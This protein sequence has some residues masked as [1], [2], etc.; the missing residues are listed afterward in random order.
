MSLP[1]FLALAESLELAKTNLPEAKVRATALARCFNARL[2]DQWWL[3]NGETPR[4]FE[5]M[6]FGTITNMG[7]PNSLIDKMEQCG[8]GRIVLD[9]NSGGGDATIALHP[10]LQN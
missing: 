7:G 1:H 3:F 10:P 2:L 9:I 8:G 4:G 6:V 5:F